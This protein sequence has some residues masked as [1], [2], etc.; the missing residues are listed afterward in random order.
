MMSSI[1]DSKSLICFGS[2]SYARSQEHHQALK[3]QEVGMAKVVCVFCDPVKGYPIVPAP[4]DCPDRKS[5]DAKAGRPPRAWLH[6]RALILG[7]VSVDWALKYFGVHW[8]S[9]EWSLQQRRAPQS[10]P[11]Q[12]TSRGQIV[13]LNPSGP[14]FT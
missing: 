3:Q 12:I 7:S 6:P 4:M 14:A 5:P 8:P 2:T 11:R 1:S 13:F 10:V 9:S